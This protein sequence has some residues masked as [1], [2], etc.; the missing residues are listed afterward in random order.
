MK[1]RVL[2]LTKCKICNSET[3]QII[4]KQ[5][6]ATYNVCDN[7]TFIYKQKKFHLSYEQEEKEYSRHNNSLENIGYV[8]M[9]KKVIDDFIIPLHIKGEVLDFGSGPVPVFVEVM[10]DYGFSMHDYDAFYNKND[11]YK[12]IK[13]DLITS[14][15]VF[16][17]FSDP[18]KEIGHLVSLLNDDGYLLI[19][20]FQRNMDLD[21]FLLWWYKRDLTHIAF[22]NNE[23]FKY[24][25]N[26]YPIKFIKTNDRDVVIFK[27]VKE[28]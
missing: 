10:K 25:E 1:E 5:I 27:K 3:H 26:L 17:H 7:C 21:E 11:E 20:T 19:K 18:L 4:D 28:M 13:Y 24:L 6:T 12:N 15:E 23:V 8:N 16:E 22:Y 9:F 14:I 2:T